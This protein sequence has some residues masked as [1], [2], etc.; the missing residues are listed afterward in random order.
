MDEEA[1]A[2]QIELIDRIHKKGGQVIMSSHVNKFMTEER[3]L[4]IAREHKRRGADIS[5][6]VSHGSSMEEQM[7][8]L[9]ITAVLNEIFLICIKKFKKFLS[10][11]LHSFLINLFFSILSK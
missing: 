9:R 8:N 2:K 3:V 10:L 11:I 6:I 7:E 5:K 1:I 4:R